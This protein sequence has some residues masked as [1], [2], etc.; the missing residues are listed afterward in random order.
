MFDY[1]AARV[2][3]DI[4]TRYTQLV[5]HRMR[6]LPDL[7]IALGNRVDRE[8]VTRQYQ[9]FV[10]THCRTFFD[11]VPIMLLALNTCRQIVFANKSGMEFLN[12][13]S[14]EDLLGMRPGEAVGCLNA[15]TGMSGCGTSKHCRHCQ[16]LSTILRAVDGFEN[17]AECRMLLRHDVR[18]EGVN[19]MV[20]ASPVV[21][22]DEH[23]VIFAITDVTHEHRRRAMERI[24]FHDVLNLAGGLRGLSELMLEGAVTEGGAEAGADELRIMHAGLESLVDEILSQRELTAA[25]SGDLTP[26]VA[27]VDTRAAL[28]NLVNLYTNLPVARGRSI[29]IAPESEGILVHTDARIL[30]RVLGNLLKNG[31]EAEGE[32]GVVTLSCRLDGDQ[33]RFSVHN[34]TPIADDLKN[35]IFRRTFSTKRGDRGLGLYSVLLLTERYLAGEPGFTSTPEKGT[36][37]FVRLPINLSGEP[38][39][40]GNA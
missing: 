40:S 13:D 12:Q 25:E 31:L 30:S 28:A 15:E 35:D 8:T 5:K 18:L 39:C 37:F 6:T 34:P 29:V 17:D 7:D 22:E 10:R 23:F 26:C 21:I 9:A 3:A 20:K 16:M 11:S 2:D 19:L 33:C 38:I 32:G 27:P 1:V 4:G 36:E 24:F 14:V